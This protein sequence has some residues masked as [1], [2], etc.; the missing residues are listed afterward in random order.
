MEKKWEKIGNYS[1]KILI[2]KDDYVLLKDYFDSG[3]NPNI[4][5]ISFDDFLSKRYDY[6]IIMDFEGWIYKEIVTEINKIKADN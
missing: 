5:K 3:K 1:S 2:L 4:T 6:E